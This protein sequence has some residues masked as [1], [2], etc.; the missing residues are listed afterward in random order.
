MVTT[1]CTPSV[2]YKRF[3]NS[4]FSKSNFDAE[5]SL[6]KATY[7]EAEDIPVYIKVK[8]SSDK[9]D[10]LKNLSGNTLEMSLNVS[11]G[12]QTLRHSGAEGYLGGD[13]FFVFKPVQENNYK[14]DLRSAYGSVKQEAILETDKTFLPAGNYQISLIKDK[15]LF[16]KEINSNVLNFE[17]KKPTGEES[18]ALNEL[19]ELYKLYP[20]PDVL[21]MYRDFAYKHYQ[22]VYIEQAFQS[23]LMIRVLGD[24]KNYSDMIIKDCKWFVDNNPNSRLTSLVIGTC[25]AVIEKYENKSK[26][27]DYLNEII[28]QY[29]DNKAGIEA[30]NLIDK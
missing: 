18:L 29:P 4:S 6:E 27:L 24:E 20:S 22:S 2:N 8:N 13:L 12:M 7:L 16:G 26:A 23:Y 5:I 10:T 11:N 25:I 30:K 28:K 15:E 1:Q 9:P 3:D 19:R 17:I 21:L 14:F